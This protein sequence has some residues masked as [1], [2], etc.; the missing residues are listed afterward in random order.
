MTSAIASRIIWAKQIESKLEQTIG[1]FR[2]II[3]H[4]GN[5]IE[6]SIIKKEYSELRNAISAY[7]QYWYT[8]WTKK[9]NVVWPALD[10]PVLARNRFNGELEMNFDKGIL[11]Q[12]G[13]RIW[14]EESV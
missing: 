12:V 13:S 9:L 1:E 2:P 4:N 8:K 14:K 7:Q 6:V 3:E 11:M 5:N 10:Q